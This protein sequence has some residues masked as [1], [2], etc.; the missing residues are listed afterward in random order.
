MWTTLKVAGDIG[1]SN[2]GDCQTG[3]YERG[4]KRVISPQL[5]SSY[6]LVRAKRVGLSWLS[7]LVH[8]FGS[9]RIRP[10]DQLPLDF[11]GEGGP[12]VCQFLPPQN[13]KREVGGKRLA[14]VRDKCE[15]PAVRGDRT[16]S[17]G[18][19]PLSRPYQSPQQPTWIRLVGQMV[20]H[21]IG[22]RYK[23]VYF[24]IDIM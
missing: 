21:S 11:I 16:C 14:I 18:G 20:G 15:H 12:L 5:T 7:I 23:T 8:R 22:L 24:Q 9:I 10:S 17:G 13:K 2:A 1:G 4:T 6:Q 3:A 19:S